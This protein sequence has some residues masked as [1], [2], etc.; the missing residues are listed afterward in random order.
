MWKSKSQSAW[1]LPY[2]SLKEPKER[3][4]DIVGS[5]PQY[6][7]H[8]EH[9]RGEEFKCAESREEGGRRR[10]ALTSGIMESH[11]EA[12]VRRVLIHTGRP[13]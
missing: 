13:S 7:Q 11:S 1:L 5:S 6:I 10:Q 2:L 8:L 4:F 3:V 9:D 12:V